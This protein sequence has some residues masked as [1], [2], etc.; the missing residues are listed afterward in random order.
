MGSRVVNCACW[1]I[2]A[3]PRPLYW[4]GHSV[5]KGGAADVTIRL[6]TFNVENLF[7]R[8]KALDTASFAD[9]EPVLEAFGDFNRIA[10]KRDYT[11]TDKEQLLAALVTLR[12]LV[13]MDGGLRPNKDPFNEAYSRA[14]FD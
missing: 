14:S 7:A 4:T 9:S 11:D 6:A 3:V 8:A 1:S 13:R 12:V 2:T 10:S 5:W